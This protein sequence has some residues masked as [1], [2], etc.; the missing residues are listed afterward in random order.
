[1]G[2]GWRGRGN[3]RLSIDLNGF[4]RGTKTA[5]KEEGGLFRALNRG[6]PMAAA[7]ETS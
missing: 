3:Y 6:R 5:F 2:G 4:P 1:M 7:S